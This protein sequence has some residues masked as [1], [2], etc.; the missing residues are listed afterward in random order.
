MS[1]KLAESAPENADWQRD[2]CVSFVRMGAISEEEQSPEAGDWWRRAH[3]TLAGMLEK[4]MHVSPQD[5]EFLETLKQKI[6]E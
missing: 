4:G 5:L 1:Q 2:L 3:D 6:D